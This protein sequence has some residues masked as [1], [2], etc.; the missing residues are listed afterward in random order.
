MQE[1]SDLEET[2]VKHAGDLGYTS[3]ELWKLKSIDSIASVASALMTTGITMFA[4]LLFLLFIGVGVALYLGEMFG[5]LYIGFALVA[6]FYLL[7]GLLIQIVFSKN[8]KNKFYE[9]IITKYYK[10]K[11]ETQV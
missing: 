7:I 9:T 8:L 11:S 2:L 5:K 4:Y 10:H 1:K 6:G 3:L